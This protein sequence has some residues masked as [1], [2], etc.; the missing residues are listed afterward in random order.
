M[1][2]CLYPESHHIDKTVCPGPN[3]FAVLTAATRFTAL[4]KILDEEGVEGL[5]K[6]LRG[7]VVQSVLTA[8]ILFWSKEKLVKMM[9]VFLLV[10]GI[11]GSPHS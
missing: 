6:G 9:A 1:V 7:K 11:R 3:F 5:F 10:S 2:I 8:A 4:R